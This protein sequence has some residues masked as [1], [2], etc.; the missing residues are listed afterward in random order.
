MNMCGRISQGEIEEWSDL[1]MVFEFPS[2]FFS[3]HNIAPTDAALVRIP[4]RKRLE[5][6]RWG[7][8]PTWADDLSFGNRTFNARLETITKKPSFRDAFAA[9]RC[10]IPVDGF[11]EWSGPKTKRVPNFV[12][13]QASP[14]WLAGLWE[15]FAKT[16][17]FTIVT[18]EA[19]STFSELHHRVPV[20]LHGTNTAQWMK[21]GKLSDGDLKQFASPDGEEMLEYYQ[22]DPLTSNGPECLEPAK[23]LDL[24]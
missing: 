15:R 2:D 12:R 21:P 9:R 23:Q 19:T 6:M 24:F 17:T 20:V 3:S 18:T 1:G 4:N 14:L 13:G 8:V 16:N 5:P 22:V 11:Y 7:L 10:A